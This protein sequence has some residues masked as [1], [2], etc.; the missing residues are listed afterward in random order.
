M[1]FT[2][3]PS[4]READDK[5]ADKPSWPLWRRLALL[6]IFLI[7]SIPL[8][9]GLGVG[10]SKNKNGGNNE[11]RNEDNSSDAE[12]RGN[13]STHTS[14]WQPEVGASWQITLVKPIQLDNDTKL[15]PGVDIYDLDLYDND[16]STFTELNKR[17]KRAIC[18]FSAGSWENWRS[19]KGDFD[20]ADLGKELDDWPGERWLNVSSQS[21]RGIMKKRIELA[22][23]KGCD[24]IDPDNVDGFVSSRLLKE[25]LIHTNSFV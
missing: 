8:G 16:K 3:S 23:Q 4:G 18:Y 10:L 11:H 25:K 13:Y 19:D 17:N 6:G 24:A 15:I 5:S 20:Q 7:I 9:V 12:P 14:I 21:V 22:A 2:A 1:G